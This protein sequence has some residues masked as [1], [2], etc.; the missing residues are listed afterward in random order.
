MRIRHDI[1]PPVVVDVVQTS[2]FDR[3][4]RGF[5]IA[6]IL[7]VGLNLHAAD[8]PVLKVYIAAK[9][10]A[11]GRHEADFPKIP[12]VGYIND[13]PDLTISQLEGVKYGL[14]P[15]YPRPGGGFTP[16]SEDRRSLD[17]QLTEKD[18]EVLRQLTYANVG[19]RLLLMLDDQPLMAPDITTPMAGQSLYIHFVP[20][21]L[22]PEELKA[23][24]DMLVQRPKETQPS[25]KP[26]PKT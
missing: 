16:P 21:E 5:L 17:L 14:Q 11:T 10:P 13:K 3:M 18:A 9:D 1:A 22:K 2:Y 26:G 15:G 12:K 6:W 23:K 24:L 8:K 25:A 20:T 4:K 7:L 19:A